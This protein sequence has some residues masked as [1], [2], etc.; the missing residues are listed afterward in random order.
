MIEVAT[1]Q[2]DAGR[3]E[4]ERRPKWR[5]FEAKITSEAKT[6]LECADQ[7]SVF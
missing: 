5:T 6:F 1:A 4:A 7:R 3:L 2:A